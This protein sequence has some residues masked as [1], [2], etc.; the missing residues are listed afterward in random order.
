MRICGS[1]VDGNGID[2]WLTQAQA[3]E[4][5]RICEVGWRDIRTACQV[6]PEH[7][8]DDESSAREEEDANQKDEVPRALAQG[9][10]T[11]KT[12][13]TAYGPGS[14]SKKRKQQAVDNDQES[15][16]G[17]RPPKRQS[18]DASSQSPPLRLHKGIICGQGASGLQESPSDGGGVFEWLSGSARP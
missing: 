9:E 4:C 15:G 3:K 5:A 14:G 11:P 6:R 7:I 2:R 8:S 13:R 1:F 12:S 16:A 18:Q 10:D 17:S